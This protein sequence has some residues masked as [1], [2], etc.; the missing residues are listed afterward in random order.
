M[1][2]SLSRLFKLLDA[3]Q[4]KN[5]IFFLILLFFSTIFEGLSIALIFPLIKII[6]DTNY[7]LELSTKYT[8]LNL[9]NFQESEIIFY[10][11]SLI[12]LMYLLKSFFLIF[13]SWWK[14]NFILKINNN[15]SQ[16]LF[17]KY[18]SSSYSF[19]FNKNSAEFIRNIYNEPRFVNLFI[20]AFLKLIVEIFSVCIIL[21]IL[22][23]IQFEITFY[24]LIFFGIFLILFNLIF[25]SRIKTWSLEKQGFVAS[26]LKNMQQSFGSIKEI[27]LRG[28]QNFFS[29]NFN[30]T[31]MSLNLRARILM[32]INEIPKNIIE[33]MT[34]LIVC[35]VVYKSYQNN[36]GLNELIPIIGLFGAAALRMMPAFNR[37]IANKQNLDECSPSIKLIFEELSDEK[38]IIINQNKRNV[39]RKNFEKEISFENINFKYKNSNNYVIKNLNFKIKKNQCI[40]FIGSSG[41]GKTTF[42]DIVSGLITPESGKIKVDG[43]ELDLND[44]GWKKNIGYV[45]QNSYLIDDSIKNNILFGLDNQNDF[46][47]ENF[48][49][50]IKDSQLDSLVNQL[51]GGVN[52]IVGENGIKLSG[53]Q[54]QRIA[55]ARSLYLRPKILIL[56]EITS[57]LDE[58]TARELLNS[59]NKLLGKIT[60]L[61]ISHN[62]NVINNA[63]IVYKISNDENNNTILSQ[64]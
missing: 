32:F 55:I 33:T 61:Y 20:D 62:D 16:R 3:S 24:T 30:Q 28:N 19:F 56:D 40:C 4:K 14:S 39:V 44:M 60:I 45:T 31:L 64:E 63:D 52:F 34:V 23:R 7:L 41:S 51:P 2:L 47:R 58:N 13:F 12:I 10:T 11:I 29:K 50:A 1:F 26:I 53:G 6:L 48:D 15:I 9:S 21:L 18:V 42:I 38:N 59:L 22:L 57:A 43:N 37:I 8:S 46:N 17:K 36:S 35:F 5:I 25:S 54:K 27:I 49:L